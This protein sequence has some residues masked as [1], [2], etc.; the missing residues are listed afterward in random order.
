[1][2]VAGAV[3]A[4]GSAD[5][6][7]REIELERPTAVITA[8]QLAGRSGLLLRR[9]ITR[10]WADLERKIAIIHD[11]PQSDIPGVVVMTRPLSRD[12]LVSLM[13]G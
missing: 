9:Q 4:A 12:A 7:L 11:T 3:R 2:K 6:A 10:R 13:V 1:V 5:H 8:A